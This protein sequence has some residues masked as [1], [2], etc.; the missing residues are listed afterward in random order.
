V[1]STADVVLDVDTG[2]DDALALI[3]AARTM[4]VRAVTCVYGNSDVDTVVANTLRVLDV[5]G[6]PIPVARGAAVPLHGAPVAPRRVHGRDG[7]GD[8]G[9][10]PP[11]GVARGTAV[12]LLRSVLTDGV[13]VVALGPLTTLAQLGPDLARIGR[14][15]VSGG[16]PGADP[17][18][19]ADPE[20]AAAVL[21]AVRRVTLYGPV[22]ADVPL[23]P[24]DV[25]PLLASADP[26]ARL[27][28]RLAAH[29]LARGAGLGDAGAVAAALRP[30]L[31]TTR[32]RDGLCVADTVDGEA[33]R[34]VFAG[35]VR[36]GR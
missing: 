26:V 16:L 19:D 12:D 13:T 35:A 36:R 29:Q 6:L 30:D 20:A 4:R 28:G 24:G 2:V 32:Q 10:P 5:L 7:L 3:L 18:L 11:R 22:F 9:L 27:A 15:M 14:L 8:L 31:L 17:N 1:R 23:R 34:R 21:G 25:P 33:V